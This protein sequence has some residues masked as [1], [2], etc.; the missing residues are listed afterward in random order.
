MNVP[1]VDVVRDH[2]LL[3]LLGQEVQAVVVVVVQG[4]GGCGLRR[5]GQS[6]VPVV[7]GGVGPLLGL[8]VNPASRRGRW[9]TLNRVPEARSV[10]LRGLGTS[11][12]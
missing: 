1:L 11:E 2:L 6:V 5:R 12:G 8:E 3:L 9:S 4:S 7:L 10:V